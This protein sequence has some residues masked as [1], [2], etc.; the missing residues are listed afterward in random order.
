MPS[1]PKTKGNGRDLGKRDSLPTTRPPPPLHGADDL[2]SLAHLARERATHL[3]AEHEN[4]LAEFLSDEPSTS[5]M[6][7]PTRESSE[8]RVKRPGRAC[9]A[10]EV[11]LPARRDHR[12][13]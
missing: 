13:E 7:A 1:A 3:A 6:P 11:L 2:G 4:A 12:R 8:V 10:E 5:P 9:V